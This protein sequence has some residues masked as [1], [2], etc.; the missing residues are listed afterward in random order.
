MMNVGDKVMID[1]FTVN[2]RHIA[3]FRSVGIFQN[4]LYEITAIERDGVFLTFKKP[5]IQVY[6]SFFK[7][8][9]RTTVGFTIE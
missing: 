5:T 8:V 1:D 3:S 2:D 7:F 4:H 9:K 6:G